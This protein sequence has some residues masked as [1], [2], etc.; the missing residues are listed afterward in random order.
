[1]GKGKVKPSLSTATASGNFRLW[2]STKEEG[3]VCGNFD[4]FEKLFDRATMPSDAGKP[5]EI[6][7]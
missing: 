3:S 5:W 6:G 1:M 7:R 2:V 4:A